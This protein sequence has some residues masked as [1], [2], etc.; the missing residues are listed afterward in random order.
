MNLA[1]M[2]Y[3]DYDGPHNPETYTISF[4]RQSS[5]TIELGSDPAG[6]IQRILNALA[7]ICPTG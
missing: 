1:P 7:S 3:K 5:Y 4:K 2:R 6:N